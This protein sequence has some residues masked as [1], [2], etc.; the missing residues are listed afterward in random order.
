MKGSLTLS[1][2]RG[3]EGLTN[4]NVIN[5]LSRVPRDRGLSPSIYFPIPIDTLNY[6]LVIWKYFGI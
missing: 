6:P 1:L 3:M 5:I 2:T 4:A